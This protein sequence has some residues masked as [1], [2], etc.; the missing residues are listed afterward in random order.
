MGNSESANTTCYDHVVTYNTSSGR[1]RGTVI[2]VIC[3]D[4]EPCTSWLLLPTENLWSEGVRGFLYIL[5]MLYL[6]IGEASTRIIQ[7]LIHFVRVYSASQVLL[8]A[9]R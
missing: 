5:G 1:H 7:I 2:E 4:K 8:T 3:G 9:H 6:F